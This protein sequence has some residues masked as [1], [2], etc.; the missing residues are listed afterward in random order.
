VFGEWVQQKSAEYF[1]APGKTGRRGDDTETGDRAY[2]DIRAER[3]E[4]S[5]PEL[6]RGTA[7]DQFIQ[8]PLNHLSTGGTSASQSEKQR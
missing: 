2:T 3:H 6:R 8:P 7:G 5:S 4:Y 1:Y